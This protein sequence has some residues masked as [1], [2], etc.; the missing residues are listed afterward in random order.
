MIILFVLY[1]LFGWLAGVVINHL[2]DVLPTRK[3]VLQKP[4]CLACE[5]VR[6]QQ[7]WSALI[8]WGTGMAQQNC[9][10]CG[11]PRKT[12]KRAIITELVVPLF[13]VFLMWRYGPSLE[14]AL[15]TIYT[16]ILILVTI[17]DLEHRLIFNVVILPS[18]LFAMAAAFFT[19]DLSWP[20]A[21]VGGVGA[22]VVVYAVALL[23]RGGLGE[24]DVTLSTFLG[25]ILAFPLIILSITFGVFL[26]GIVAAIL[27]VSG[28][29]NLKTFIP[30]G[31]FLTITGWIMLVW[32]GEIWQYFFW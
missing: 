8:A 11:T 24:G 21:Y 1:A 29:V 6:P 15:V 26:G 13:F 2:A 7:Q 18:I 32:G 19:P 10:M 5:T 12:Y 3:T 31:P 27:L 14:L 16:F 17:T 22:F 20:A 23:S 28:K 9:L 4:F 30:Y 25:F